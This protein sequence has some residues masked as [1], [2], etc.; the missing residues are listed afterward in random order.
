MFTYNLYFL[1]GPEVTI[2]KLGN[3]IF[4]PNIERFDDNVIKLGDHNND[5]LG[6]ISLCPGGV[7]LSLWF[8]IE[9]YITNWSHLFRSTSFYCP[10]H[11]NATSCA[12]YVYVRNESHM[13]QFPSFTDLS[14][15]KWHHMGIACDE[16]SS[17]VVYIDGCV[18]SGTYKVT[19]QENL[20][21]R[22]DFELGCDNGNKCTRVHYDELR[23]WTV[24][25][26][27]LFMWW[28]WNLYV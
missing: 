9:Y 16:S 25:K 2:G 27:Q 15:G 17:C 14:Y 12:L 1:T 8:K 26:S 13:Q 3:A 11:C 6:N 23:F 18:P 21:D 19:R 22:K 24:K 4:L 28:L 7:T 5:C 20:V 10:M